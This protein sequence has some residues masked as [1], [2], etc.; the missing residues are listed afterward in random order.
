MADAAAR[1]RERNEDVLAEAD[2]TSEQVKRIQVDSDA[3]LGAVNS[4][5]HSLIRAVRTSTPEI[6]RRKHPRRPCLIEGRI[7]TSQRQEA[8]LIHELS[9]G[10][11]SLDTRSQYAIGELVHIELQRFGISVQARV[12]AQSTDKLHVRFDEPGLST[13]DVDRMS[14]ETVAEILTLAKDQHLA[15][16]KRIADAVAAR[17][18]LSPEELPNHRDC[19]FGRSL[20]SISDH[21]ALRLPSFQAIIA[22]HRDV[23]ETA[24]RALVQLA[25]G[26]IGGA[27]HE[28]ADLQ[29]HTRKVLHH[30]EAFQRDYTAMRGDG[31]VT[32]PSA[33]APAADVAV[34]G[35]GSRLL[36]HPRRNGVSALA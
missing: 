3:L 28:V 14:V 34:D 8:A 11:C 7:I 20:H 4:L 12:T 5:Q 35:R 29:E 26:N 16:A 19:P 32:E 17:N 6:D 36:V 25:A 27:E 9:E 18:K 13:A 33:H 23:H 15:F 31:T 1:I 21:S 2:A 10:G 30:L 22:P 24:H